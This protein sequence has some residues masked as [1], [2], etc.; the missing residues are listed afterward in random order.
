MPATFPAHP[1]A[2]LPLKLAYPR[3][4]DGVA[5]VLG[6]AA[7]DLPYVVE[8]FG[9]T[10]RG[11]SW[12]GL[13]WFCLPA[14][15]ILAALVRRA[16]PHVAAH[17][18]NGGVLALRD[19]G[20]LAATRYPLR[21]SAL[22]ALLGAATHVA[23]DSVTHPYILVGHPF[24]GEDTYLTA[25]HATAIAGLPWW[26]VIH[27]ASEV[28]GAVIVGACLVHIGRH[29]LPVAWHGTPPVVPR[30]PVVFAATAAIA[31]SALLAI[32][33]VLPGNGIGPYVIGFRLLAA[34]ALTM[35]LAGA[36]TAGWP[37]TNQSD[38]P[39]AARR[40]THP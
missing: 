39:P 17:L 12:H 14:T 24:I 11:H 22:C 30:R 36:V 38:R 29:R 6:A 10:V 31:G 9:F 23:W 32:V 13:F 27:L 37:A 5:L 18:P 35:L 1:A 20:G 19:Y 33:L 8:G 26:R 28:A 16:A 4:L 7:P 34:A 40:G 3:R 2:I 15:L 25:M 21:V